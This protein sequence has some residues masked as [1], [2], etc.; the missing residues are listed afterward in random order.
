MTQAAMKERWW[1]GRQH[2]GDAAS[3]AHE[4]MRAGKASISCWRKFNRIEK[5]IANTRRLRPGSV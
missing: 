5:V 3:Y 2:R 1:P 4:K